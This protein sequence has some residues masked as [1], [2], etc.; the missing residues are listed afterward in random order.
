[1]FIKTLNRH[2][3]SC[4]FPWRLTLSVVAV[5][6]L[7]A[8]AHVAADEVPVRRIDL[9]VPAD[10]LPYLLEQQL[11]WNRRDAY[12]FASAPDLDGD[13]VSEFAYVYSSLLPDVGY[14]SAVVAQSRAAG[15]DVLFQYNGPHLSRRIWT[16]RVC[17]V[18]GGP[19]DEVALVK[20][21][22]N[23][24]IIEIVG[25]DEHGQMTSESLVAAVGSGIPPGQTWHDLSVEVQTGLDLNGD[26]NREL[27][28]SRSA[29]PDSSFER[30]LVAYDLKNKRVLWFFPLADGVG[31]GGAYHQ[32]LHVVPR[33]EG[34]PIIVFTTMANM[35]RYVANGMDSRYAYLVAVDSEGHEL[36]RHV[37][38]GPGFVY[39]FTAWLDVNNDGTEEL[40]A[41]T[42][43][44]QGG[45]LVSS[46]VN[47]FNPVDGRILASS[48][49]L[50]GKFNGLY[51][52]SDSRQGDHRLLVAVATGGKVDLLTLD[53]ELKV[54]LR[55]VSDVFGIDLTVDL[56]ADSVDEIVARTDGG[57][58]CVLSRDFE[59]L[60]S[61]PWGGSTIVYSADGLRR[62]LLNSELWGCGL[63]TLHKQGLATLMWNRHHWWLA[64]LAAAGF[65]YL[66]LRFARWVMHLYTSSAGLP[67]LD[68]IN[69]LV[70]VLDRKGRIVFLNNNALGPL[71][72]GER[73]R[74]RQYL[75][76]TGMTRYPIVVETVARS[77]NDPYLPLQTQFETEDGDKGSRRIDL[78]VYPRLDSRN[79]YLG[80][81][82]IAEDITDRVGWERK[83]VLGEAAQRW[84]HKLKG[85]MATARITLDNLREDRR[86]AG[87]VSANDVLS[88]YLN[89]VNDRIVD[90]ADT[91]AK[92]LRFLRIAK[93]EK[94][95][96]D[97]NQLVGRVVK[98]YQHNVPSSIAVAF[99]PQNG[100]P[101]VDADPEQ[102][103]EVLDN[104]L[105][106]AMV[107]VGGEGKITVSV[108]LA[109]SLHATNDRRTVEITVEDTGR[110]I[111]PADL[112]K[113]FTPGFTKSGGG[114]GIGLAIVKEIV[115][116]HGG[117]VDV[118]SR[119]G[120]GSRFTVRI[121]CDG[122]SV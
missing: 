34:G 115:D 118:D 48:E 85:N 122:D 25:M 29:K 20:T 6:A 101:L 67:S 81:I 80:K 94:V 17:D 95:A 51:V 52:T 15:G 70:L 114:T 14:R 84:V 88:G 110:G 103:V 56:N 79:S 28:Y 82:L 53:T 75:A 46:V 33:V 1:M 92:I 104:L 76:K 13:G 59:L 9:A 116:N 117:T 107:A 60:A 57:G 12:Y 120:K 74:S 111:E 8:P 106:N 63:L 113:L 45:S 102:I 68:R 16:S 24:V 22:G 5:L 108:Q 69:A 38:G 4:L 32:A 55:A 99:L 26:G 87:I 50:A 89:S 31:A 77:F 47:C 36:W 86:V 30:G 97:I 66:A 109:E 10:E 98:P 54:R 65:L 35:N 2:R 44:F 105:S 49:S 112:N 39:P 61:S 58:T 23:S 64:V 27:I 121:P 40:F 7:S 90:S 72:L 18:M 78:V 91:A 41:P 19:G 93:P 42:Y 100:L 73:L 62:L 96:C 37:L 3:P 71:L 21:V 11:L 43:T 83:V 119:P